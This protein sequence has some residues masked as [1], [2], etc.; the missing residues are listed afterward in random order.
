MRKS[1][2]LKKGNSNRSGRLPS[3]SSI[4]NL[5]LIT[6]SYILPE[7]ELMIFVWTSPHI[8][9]SRCFHFESLLKRGICN[10]QR[11]K[12]KYLSI[13]YSVFFRGTDIL[14]SW[15]YSTAVSQNTEVL[16]MEWTGVTV[17]ELG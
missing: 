4:A 12:F 13:K 11:D 8:S 14:T 10:F 15:L 17:V 6:C 9:N 2:G 5:R 1:L 3:L 7:A 16:K